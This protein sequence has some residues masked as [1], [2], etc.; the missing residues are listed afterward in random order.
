MGVR[1]GDCKEGI[2]VVNRHKGWRGENGVV[3]DPLV[4]LNIAEEK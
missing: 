1:H 3:Q 2:G 4:A